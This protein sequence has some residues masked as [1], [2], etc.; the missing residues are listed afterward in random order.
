MQSIAAKVV[1]LGSQAVGK[2]SITIRYVDK[3]FSKKETPTIGASF[4]TSKMIVENVKVKL[5]IWDTAGQERFKSMAPIFY[6]NSNAA[7]IVFDI[8]RENTFQDVYYWVNELRRNIEEKV[9]LCLVGNKSDLESER[10]V[11]FK[12]AFNYAL[13]ID[14]QYMETS[15]LENNGIDEAFTLLGIAIV[16]RSQELMKKASKNVQ[17]HDERTEIEPKQSF[18]C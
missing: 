2:T 10:Q 14:A 13:S 1:I 3:K 4:F 8:T 7:I 16:E 5:Q 6:R 15:A 11:S 9:V 18:L 12:D 17:T